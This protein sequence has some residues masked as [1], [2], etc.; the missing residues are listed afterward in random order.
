V[1]AAD[2]RPLA[3][4]VTVAAVGEAVA[5]AVEEAEATAVEA[6]VA[7]AITNSK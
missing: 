6:T 7:A 5:T 2:T 3:V 4:E 1:V